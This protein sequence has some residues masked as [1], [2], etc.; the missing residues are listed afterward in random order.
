MKRASLTLLCLV[1]LLALGAVW[2]FGDTPAPSD[3]ASL[4]TGP[5]CKLSENLARTG[6]SAVS[7]EERREPGKKKEP[8]GTPEV[9][10]PTEKN[11]F[12]QVCIEPESGQCVAFETECV[13]DDLG[14][15]CSIGN[16][17][18]P[19]DEPGQHWHKITCPCKCKYTGGSCNDSQIRLICY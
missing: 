1:S 4:N 15:Y 19:C 7:V 6:T 14:E 16:H 5:T 13:D 17:A 2:A 10:C 18:F 12:P 3:K 11:C 9:Q 8:T